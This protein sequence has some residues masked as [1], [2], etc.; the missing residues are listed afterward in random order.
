MALYKKKIS[1]LPSLGR[2]LKGFFTVGYKSGEEQNE[3]YRVDLGF[4]EEAAFD[5]QDS[6]AGAQAATVSARE[7]AEEARETTAA[8]AAAAQTASSAAENAGQQAA[9]ATAQGD[10]AREQ[11]S[12][13]DEKIGGKVDKTQ[14]GQAGGVAALDMNGQ[15]PLGQLPEDFKDKALGF[16]YNPNGETPQNFQQNNAEIIYSLAEQLVCGKHPQC[17]LNIVHSQGL[18]AFPLEYTFIKNASAL[19]INLFVNVSSPNDGAFY[20]TGLNGEITTT[21]TEDIPGSTL[22]QSISPTM[23]GFSTPSDI[24]YVAKNLIKRDLITAKNSDSGT[25]LEITASGLIFFGSASNNAA[26]DFGA[27]L[28]KNGQYTFR[29]RA[30]VNTVSWASHYLYYGNRAVSEAFTIHKEQMNEILVSFKI[31]DYSPEKTLQLRQLS[32]QSYI[33]DQLK[34]EEGTK[35]TPWCPNPEDIV[36]SQDYTSLREQI[37]PGEFAFDFNGERKQ[38]YIRTWIG[39]IPNKGLDDYATFHTGVVTTGCEAVKVVVWNKNGYAS[40]LSAHAQ[41]L[42]DGSQG[43]LFIFSN[44]AMT[45]NP[46]DRF[47]ITVKYTK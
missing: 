26:V 37:V 4:V 44:Y 9:Y 11:G 24:P 5:A 47:F 3:S 36:L 39:Y 29:C 7:A 1:E 46:G 19:A 43:M 41:Q 13:I 2:A 21:N 28:S 16:Q 45:F 30:K 38:V 14:V 42:R 35:A 32:G 15:V 27:I 31:T 12:T 33:F 6:A 8:A 20:A 23:Q 25:P 18:Y 34:L 17:I 40:N 10:Y 22:V